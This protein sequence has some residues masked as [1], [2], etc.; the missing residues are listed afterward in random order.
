MNLGNTCFMNA[1]L[2]CLAGTTSLLD[3]IAVQ[4]GGEE[5]TKKDLYASFLTQMVQSPGQI[6]R[7]SRLEEDI[8]QVL[9]T[10]Q[11][12]R[13]EDAHEY[14][15]RLMEHRGQAYDHIFASYMYTLSECGHCARSWETPQPERFTHFSLEVTPGPGVLRTTLTDCLAMFREVH[16]WRKRACAC[17]STTVA[18][19]LIRVKSNRPTQ[20]W[21]TLATIVN[22]RRSCQDGG[23]SK[24]MDSQ[25]CSC[26]TSNASIRLL[27]M[28]LAT[29]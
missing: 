7:P 13:M 21:I 2:Q 10:H 18:R 4:D 17:G 28:N 8:T 19:P 24:K 3:L 14:F 29:R 27:M 20:R 9:S 25:R 12:G 16:V 5:P 11:T 22:T 6:L 15:A 26:S 1:V 23:V